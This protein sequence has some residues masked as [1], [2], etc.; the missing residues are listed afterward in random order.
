MSKKRFTLIELL[1]V[2][3]IIAILA[4]ILLPA[5]QSAR[6]RAQSSSCVSNLKNLGAYATLY[7]GDNRNLWPTTNTTTIGSTTAGEIRNF[8]WPTCLIYGKYTPDWRLNGDLKKRQYVSSM[9][10]PDNDAYRCPSIPFC[11]SSG[12]FN[13]FTVPQTYATPLF[14]EAVRS[15]AHG[16]CLNLSAPRLNDVFKSGSTVYDDITSS[17]SS[18]IWLA[19]S[20]YAQAKYPYY[21]RPGFHTWATATLTSGA[22][23]TNPHNG[24]LNILTHSGAVVGVGG[25]D[26]REYYGLW[27]MSEALKYVVVSRRPACYRDFGTGEPVKL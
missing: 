19:D 11:T 27:N 6:A 26:L 23:L 12:L 4:A 24:R 25:D 9:I 1:V 3:A 20:T 10:Y 13:Q 16:H 14:Y 15:A 8:L 17:P 7:V 5:L 18:R 22:V 21:A 2:I